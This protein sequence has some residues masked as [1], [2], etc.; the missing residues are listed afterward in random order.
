MY[1]CIMEKKTLYKKKLVLKN[2]VIKILL[3]LIKAL[4]LYRSGNSKKKKK[5]IHSDP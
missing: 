5:I 4:F 3:Q 1:V 2:T